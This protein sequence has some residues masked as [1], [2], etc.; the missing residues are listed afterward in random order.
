MPHPPNLT[1][2]QRAEIRRRFEADESVKRLAAEYRV[3]TSTIHN[4]R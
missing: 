2:A 1:A 3:S 4:C